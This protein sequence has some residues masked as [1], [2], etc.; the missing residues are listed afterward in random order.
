M[1]VMKKLINYLALTLILTSIISCTN[2]DNDDNIPANSGNYF[3]LTIDNYWNYDITNSNLDLNQTQ[4]T[5]DSLYVNTANNNEF[6]LAVN[7]IATGTM[8][9][10]FTQMQLTRTSS[11]L[12]G[13]GSVTFPFEGIE[14]LQIGVNNVVLY[15]INASVNEDLSVVEGELLY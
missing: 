10:F 1:D 4:N 8:N 2:S 6:E 12:I 3:P 13:S 7:G 15:D 14:D 11:T 9:T 5:R